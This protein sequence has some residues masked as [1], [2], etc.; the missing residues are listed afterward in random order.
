MEVL[1][2]IAWIGTAKEDL[3]S[4]PKTVQRDVGFSLHQVQEGKHPKNVKPLKGIDTG[5]GE[6]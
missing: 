3:K 6:S 4:F 5:V 2:E 1:K